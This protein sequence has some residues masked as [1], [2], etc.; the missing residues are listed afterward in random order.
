MR[1][2]I[3]SLLLAALLTLALAPSAFAQSDP[4]DG[5]RQRIESLSHDE[6]KAYTLDLASLIE[7]QAKLV[8]DSIAENSNLMVRMESIGVELVELRKV[9]ERIETQKKER[10]VTRWFNFF[11]KIGPVL[12]AVLR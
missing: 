1:S 8:S 9:I 12:I 4:L 2:R 7:D 6:L 10:K 3:L 11:T 5:Y